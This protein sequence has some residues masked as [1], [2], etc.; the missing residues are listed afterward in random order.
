VKKQDPQV[1]AIV[2]DDQLQQLAAGVRGPLL[3]PGDD[4]FDAARRVWNG[5]IDRS[6]ALIIR[7]AGVADVLSAVR[8]ARARGLP[9]AVRG[10]GHNVAGKGVCEG[11]IQI[12][13]SPMKGIR[14]DPAARTARA[15]AG[16]TWG[17]FNHETHAFGLAVTG[18]H[19]STTGISGLT[20]GGGIGWLMRKYGLTSDNLLSADLV[21]ADGRFVTASASEN[22]DLFWGLRG[23]GGNF[24]IVT[25]FEYRLHPAETVLAGIVFYRAD[26]ARE[27]LR[28]Y[29]EFAEKSPDELTTLAVFLTGPPAPFL[30]EELHGAPLIAVMGCYTGDLNEGERVL[31]PL[32]RF[33]PPAVDV[34]QAMPYPVLNTM[35][36]PAYPPGLQYYWKTGYLDAIS[37]AAIDTLIAH[38]GSVPSP[39]TTVAVMQLGG[40][41]SRVGEEETPSSLRRRQ[42]AVN[43]MSAWPN[44]ADS[45]QNIQWTR[46][47][48]AAIEPF[49]TGG[50]FVSFLGEEG[51][52]G[53]RAA[54]GPSTYERLVRLKNKYDPT[55]MFQMNQNIPPSV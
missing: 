13:V 22:A 31:Q 51:Q 25:S 39:L 24:G 2:T 10:G 5:M 18:G 29:R 14:V 44:P 6:P 16:L 17:E 43:I 27:V 37:D 23:G 48:S 41:V 28:F 30:P 52:D 26:R 36:D 21:T 32:R 20:L 1:S 49:A 11:G 7:C 8:F 9:L 40:A 3:R 33:G 4:G 50:A 15:Q 42:Y 54:Y 35:L 38:A 19:V 53:V 46:E 45:D 55:N 47:F 12:D 34:Y